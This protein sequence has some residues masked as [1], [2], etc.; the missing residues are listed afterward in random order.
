M[1]SRL[2]AGLSFLILT[3]WFHFELVKDHTKENKK[4]ELNLGK[5]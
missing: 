5:P 3:H 1:M 2:T 4:A